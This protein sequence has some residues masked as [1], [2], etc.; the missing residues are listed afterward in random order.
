M[1]ENLKI[2]LVLT[3]TCIACSFCLALVNGLAKDKIEANGKKKIEDAIAVLMPRAARIDV[4][5]GDMPLW[6]LSDVSGKPL[7]F[8]F[9]IKGDGYQGTIKILGVADALVTRLEGIEIIESVE[10]PGLG[11]RIKEDFFK[12]RFSGL[13][14]RNPIECVKEEPNRAGQI[15]AISSATISSKA[16]VSILN[17]NMDVVRERLKEES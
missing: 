8:A 13:D 5:A 9:L 15:K 6:K 16:V 12:K 3:V 4:I 1:K 14:I 17:K 2:I 11:A 7:G 10:T